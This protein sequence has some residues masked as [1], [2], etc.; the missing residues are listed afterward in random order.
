MVDVAR[1]GLEAETP[2]NPYS[3]L[4]AVND[5]SDTV[6]TGWLIFL[7]IMTY[8]VIAVAGVTHKDLL[9]ETP[10]TLPILQVPIPLKQFFQFAPLVLVLFHLGVVAQLVLLSRKTLEF[11]HAIR[12]LETS[13]RRTH[14][15]R[16]E[17]HNF[18]FVQAIAGPHRS[19]IMSAFLHGMSWL[20]VVIIPVI[21]LLYIQVTFLPYHDVGITWMHRLLLVIDC[22]ALM[23]IGV[24]LVRTESSFWS[25]HVR[26]AQRHPFNV[27]FTTTLLLGV[28]GLSFLVATV[29]GEGMAKLSEAIFGKPRAA[30]GRERADAGFNLAGLWSG[31]DGSMFGLFQRNLIVTDTDLVVDKEVTAGEPTLKLRGRDLRYA[32]LDR[33]DLHQADFT[34]SNIDDASLAGADLGGSTMN[35]ADLNNLVLTEDRQA[36]NCVSARRVNLKGA[37][38]TGANLAGINLRSA[39]LDDAHLEDCDL[40]YAQLVDAKFASAHL[41][42]AD[43]TGG[44]HAEGTNF[45]LANLSG[46]DLTGAILHLADFTQATMLGANFSFAHLQGATLRSADLDAAAL[47]QAKLVG[48][49]MTG[50]KITAADL[51]GAHVWQTAAADADPAAL[52]DFSEF[53]LRPLDQGDVTALTAALARIPDEAVREEVRE[54]LSR[55]IDLAESRK[56]GG[57]E[58]HLRW[59]QF[60]TPPPVLPIGTDTKTRLTEYLTR[61]MCK[62]RWVNGAFATGVVR[63]AITQQFKGDILAVHDALKADSCA[64]G[65]QVPPRLMQTLSSA[66]D[67]IRNN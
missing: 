63:R 31:A 28:L 51:R 26:N 14:P 18:F 62:T 45:L 33:S 23:L 43:L 32:R 8:L 46:A 7:A 22:V 29:P 17:L 39:R 55:L 13:D 48:A 16:L 27:T 42:R 66:V 59:Q 35:C 54:R 30:Q 9:L 47:Y 3:L 25:A 50:A 1:G 4:E 67:L 20:T 53:V 38:L 41:E 12:L 58:A 61:G 19:R 40:S 10:V 37:K 6:N 5:S 64:A 60:M 34:G 65:R 57:S 36:S 24:F 15:L 52:A 44:I 21:L 11:D 2:V 56:W 49:D